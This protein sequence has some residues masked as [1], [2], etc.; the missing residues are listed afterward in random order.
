MIEK[1]VDA[2]K[3][4]LE[5]MDKEYCKLSQIDYSKVEVDSS[6]L[7]EAKYLERPFAY[8]FYHQLRTLLDRKDVNFGGP[9]IQAEV[10]K[11]YQHCF[12]SGKVPDFIIHIPNIPQ[13]LA[14]IEFKLSTNSNIEDDFKKLVEFKRNRSLQYAYAVAVIIGNK[15]SLRRIKNLIKRLHNPKG[16]E[17]IVIEFDIDSWQAKET[18]FQY[19]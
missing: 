12:T 10:D 18:I 3:K 9:I 16:E 6:K 15:K 7:V 5:N 1:V 13:N 17:I 11:E 8:E 4:A 14:V 19:E 2:I